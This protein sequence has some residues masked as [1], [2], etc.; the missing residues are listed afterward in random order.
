MA[1]LCL[2]TFL[3]GGC[4]TSPG[5]R[6]E[7]VARQRMPL[8]EVTIEELLLLYESRAHAIKTLEVLLTVRMEVSSVIHSFKGVLRFE[9]PRRVRLQG[10]DLL[11]RTVLD[12]LSVGEDF[13]LSLPQEGKVL[14]G[15]VQEFFPDLMMVLLGPFGGLILDPAEVAALEKREEEYLLYVLLI[16]GARARIHRRLWIERRGFL[17]TKEELFDSSGSIRSVIRYEDFRL[18]G[19][20]LRP[21]KIEA[22]VGNSTRLLALI[23]EVHLNPTLS[24]EDFRVGEE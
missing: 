15:E 24:P 16:D 9:E 5:R 23:H 2:S 21:F 7:V 12:F 10:F 14:S 4:L 1:V 17:V 11:G 13:H 3:L 19:G 6:R 20:D 8:R 18:M 22:E